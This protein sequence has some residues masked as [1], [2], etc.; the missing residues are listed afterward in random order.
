MDSAVISLGQES[1]DSMTRVLWASSGLDKVW[2][3]WSPSSVLSRLPLCFLD[4]SLSRWSRSILG[5]WEMQQKEIN[6]CILCYI[7][8]WCVLPQPAGRVLQLNCKTLCFVLNG[9]GS[10]PFCS[11]ERMHTG[12]GARS[13]YKL[14]VQQYTVLY[15]AIFGILKEQGNEPKLNQT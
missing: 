14:C 5:H 3:F 11:E 7:S 13:V 12:L 6:R 8:L 9:R 2:S 4:L 1:V 15:G 10:E